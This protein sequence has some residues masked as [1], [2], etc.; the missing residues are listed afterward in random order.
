MRGSA[1]LYALGVGVACLIGLLCTPS[2][3]WVVR[4]HVGV[5][6]DEWRLALGD[7]ERPIVGEPSG[8]W[9]RGLAARPEVNA[10]ERSLAYALGAASD[11][12][13]LEAV[14]GMDEAARNLNDAARAV[15]VVRHWV[16]WTAEGKSPERRNSLTDSCRRAILLDPGNAYVWL[17]MAYAL[18]AG[19]ANENDVCEVLLHAASL[20][21]YSDYIVYES[22]AITGVFRRTRGYRGEFVEQLVLPDSLPTTSDRMLAAVAE[23][24]VEHELAGTVIGDA[25]G[26]TVRRAFVSTRTGREFGAVSGALLTIRDAIR[27]VPG[28]SSRARYEKARR[29]AG[30]DAYL[31]EIETTIRRLRGRLTAPRLDRDRFSAGIVARACLIGCLVATAVAGALALVFRR[32]TIPEWPPFAAAGIGFAIAFWLRG[33]TAALLPAAC[34]LMLGSRSLGGRLRQ[35]LAAIA[36]AGAIWV[37]VRDVVALAP[38]VALALALA[39]RAPRLSSPAI[40]VPAFSLLMTGTWVLNAAAGLPPVYRVIL[41]AIMVPGLL[42]LTSAARPAQVRTVVGVTLAVVSIAYLF[43]VAEETRANERLRAT[44]AS[45]RYEIERAKSSALLEV[46]AG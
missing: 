11:R 29:T 4:L 36:V 24:V 35:A 34:A 27:V 9:D 46:G 8:L 14:A 39:R 43:G 33:D 13:R 10:F 6:T 30:Y 25:A 31:R 12:E 42:A 21:N 28:D 32:K 17:C 16:A 19:E 15:I 7:W 37:G 38:L 40:L 18:V 44:E 3:Y 26:Q 20:A 22:E 2:S 41:A 23:W 5:L 45:W 1:G